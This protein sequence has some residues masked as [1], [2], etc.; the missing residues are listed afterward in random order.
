MPEWLRRLTRNQMGSSRAGSN[1]V[2]CDTHLQEGQFFTWVS[3]LCFFLR[4]V[5]SIKLLRFSYLIFEKKR[6]RVESKFSN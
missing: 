6:C 2:G 5:S 3:I 1:P 4:F